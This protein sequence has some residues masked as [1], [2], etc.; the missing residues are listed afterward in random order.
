[1]SSHGSTACLNVILRNTAASGCKQSGWNR[2]LDI[3]PSILGYLD[4][5]IQD[6][7]D[8][9]TYTEEVVRRRSH[10]VEKKTSR[11]HLH[12]I[13][14]IIG[15]HTETT[16]VHPI[17]PG[18]HVVW[19]FDNVA[20]QPV[21]RSNQD[22]TWE[23]EMVACVFSRE[24][25]NMGQY[26]A[27]VADFVGL[28]GKFGEDPIIRR[29]IIQ[30]LR[31][32][33]YV[34]A[35]S[36]TLPVDMPLPNGTVRRFHLGPTNQNG[37]LTQ[38]VSLPQMGIV[39]RSVV[40][41]ELVG[42]RGQVRMQT[43]FA[44][45]EG[46]LLISDIDDSIKVTLTP[47]TVGILRTTFVTDPEPIIGMPELY[48]L[49]ERELNPTWIYL[50]ASPYNLYKFLRNFLHLF[51]PPGTLLLRQATWKNLGE[52]IK[53]YNT[54]TGTYK[55]RQMDKI[56]SWLPARKVICV[57]D[58]TQSDPEI[59]AEMYRRHAGWIKAIFIRKVTNIPHME[60]KNSSSRFQRA[61]EGVP[62]DV[63]RI[64]ERPS[65]LYESIAKLNYEPS[66]RQVRV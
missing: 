40:T 66:A 55:M 29:R 56:H 22:Q 13:L 33:L 50:S 11:K 43:R 34:V 19:L 17:K 26:V 1:M 36:R 4:I 6:M 37:V 51:Y 62:H 16:T 2:I 23:A 5:I 44:A 54:G 30:R 52:F 59:Y 18:Q 14:R 24:R 21:H 12:R 60:K 58:S 20:Y 8:I 53:S 41:S 65:G 64:F 46:W 47:E 39:D 38:T 48:Q 35:P 31:S 10:S 57:G 42:S 61:F 28:D 15:F 27:R 25:R 63:W 45:P 9:K 49:I 7:A 32:L 3:V